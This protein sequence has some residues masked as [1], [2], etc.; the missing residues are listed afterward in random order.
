M[1]HYVDTS[2]LT[3]LVVIE[4]G[5]TALQTWLQ[6]ENR[7]PVTSNLVRTELLRAVRRIS[8]SSSLPKILVTSSSSPSSPKSANEGRSTPGAV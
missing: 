3:K 8:S 7:S 2:A 1:A 4:P 5:T 6:I